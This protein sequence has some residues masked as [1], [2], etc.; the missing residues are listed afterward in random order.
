MDLEV[1]GRNEMADMPNDHIVEVIYSSASFNEHV[2]VLTSDITYQV[3]EVIS[4]EH[5][6]E[7]YEYDKDNL[8]NNAIVIDHGPY[9]MQQ[10]YE[11]KI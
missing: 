9:W 7:E 3:V 11:R 6:V 4:G 10:Y 5:F 2:F 1:N 8:N